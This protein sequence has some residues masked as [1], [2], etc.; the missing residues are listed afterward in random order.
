M[1]R[2]N[3]HDLD[4]PLGPAERGLWLMDAGA[5]LNYCLVAR[6][7][8]G[9]HEHLLRA[10][11]DAAQA[12]HPPL[13][14]R[15]EES[16]GLL[17]FR[18]DDVGPIPLS[19]E[20]GPE[21]AWL[22]R[23]EDDLT[24]RHPAAGPLLRVILHQHDDNDAVT[25]LMSSHH[26][27]GDGRSG[28]SLLRDVLTAAGRIA[29]GGPPGLSPL[30]AT[31]PIEDLLPASARGLRGAFRNAL[32]MARTSV[33]AARNGAPLPV[34]QEQ[35]TPAHSRRARIHPVVL[36]PRTTGRLMERCRSERTTVHGALSAAMILGILADHGA[37]AGA[38]YGS[39]AGSGAAAG[40]AADT[41]GFGIPVDMRPLLE[42]S[43]DD[44]LGFYVS[45]ISYERRLSADAE[46]WELARDIRDR[47]VAGRRRRDDVSVVAM[48]PRLGRWLGAERLP[49]R[50]FVESWERHV[51][52]TGG[53]TNMGRLDIPT[54]Y[55]ALSLETCHLAF[56][57]SALGQFSAGVSSLD[58]QLFWDFTWPDPSMTRAHADALIGGIVET[59]RR[60]I[61]A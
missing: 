57:P 3:S 27:I 15:V 2:V 30:A 36:D 5:P 31:S 58:D 37:G 55:G 48:S 47:V 11:L 23:V 14:A 12:R 45:M 6:V 49:P 22:T 19:V 43:V 51:R 26:V 4:R 13:R 20:R 35:E 28:V 34:R 33:A 59:L 41:V 60:A 42:P 24:Q 56:T 44:A 29:A 50:E 40:H 32:F 53:L 52:G 61:G 7:A 17:R 54:A 39:G 1:R 10:A 46:L 38:G 25:L 16:A 8:G 21:S 18:S 9:L